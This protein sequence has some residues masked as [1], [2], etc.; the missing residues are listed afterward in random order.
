MN[1]TKKPILIGL[2]MGPVML[3]MLHR[4]L[5]GDTGGYTGAA[6]LAFAGL[7][8]LLGAVVFV[9]AIFAARLS[10]GARDWMDRL[11]RPKPA[12]FALMLL[13]AGFSAGVV[14]LSLHMESLWT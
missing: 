9:G 10:P 6:L 7:H 2:I 5:T 12:H 8:V 3:W 13:S 14:H 4:M 11:H 1:D